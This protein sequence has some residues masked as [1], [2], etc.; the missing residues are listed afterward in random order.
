MAMRSS[1]K[2]QFTVMTPPSLKYK[3]SMRGLGICMTGVILLRKMNPRGGLRYHRPRQRWLGETPG[4][5]VRL[6]G[7][8]AP[9]GLGGVTEERKNED[10]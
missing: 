8:N 10:A 6:K 5:V 4:R 1:R 3:F 2:P 7:E 9:T